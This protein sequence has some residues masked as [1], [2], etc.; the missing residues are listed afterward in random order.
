MKRLMT[1]SAVGVLIIAASSA[2]A[3]LMNNGDFETG[4][5][6]GWTVFTTT[7][8]TVG[9]PSL[10]DVVLFDTNNDGTATNSARF[11]VGRVDYYAGGRRGGGIYQNVNVGAPGSYRLQADVAV[12][13]SY[14]NLDAGLFELLFDSIVV[15]SYDFGSISANDSDHALLAADLVGVTA[16]THEVRIRM[17]RNF[18]IRDYTPRQYIDNVSLVPV[19]GAALLGMIGLGAVGVKLRKFA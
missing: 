16:G 1:I 3:D 7:N 8:G 4:D 11:N 6:T 18:E 17:G 2:Q 14:G 10:P 19:P 15:D 9:G 5:L 13:S 12:A